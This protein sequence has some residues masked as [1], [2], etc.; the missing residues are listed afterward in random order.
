MT[1]K[2]FDLKQRNKGGRDGRRMVPNAKEKRPEKK[3]GDLRVRSLVREYYK[4]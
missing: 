3:Q 1:W 4:N 2:Y